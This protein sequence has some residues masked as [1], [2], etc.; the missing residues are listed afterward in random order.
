MEPLTLRIPSPPGSSPSGGQ[1]ADLLR[2]WIDHTPFAAQLVDV[3]VPPDRE[4]AVATLVEGERTLEVRLHHG[5][6]ED[7]WLLDAATRVIP[8]PEE[9]TTHGWSV[10]AGFVMAILGIV[11]SVRW[12]TFGLAPFL[13]GVGVSVG[14]GFLVGGMTYSRARDRQA[15]RATRLGGGQEPARAL[16]DHL[17][18][19]V[20]QDE[21]VLPA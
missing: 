21:R 9:P 11:L 8:T 20:W 4:E 17:A 19:I 14:I 16:M 13:V 7:L 5:A 6:S 10:L 2:G 15:T 3:R 18:H 1:L 12:L